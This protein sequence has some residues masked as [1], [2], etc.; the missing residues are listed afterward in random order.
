[1][2]R[3]HHRQL[4]NEFTASPIQKNDLL[5]NNFG[6]MWLYLRKENHEE[7]R[8]IVIFGIEDFAEIAYEYF[9]HDSYYEVVHSM[10]HGAYASASEIR[11]LTDREL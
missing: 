3:S 6:T 2:S 10:V 9:T 4:K 1:M 11:R 8:K 5:L 7:L